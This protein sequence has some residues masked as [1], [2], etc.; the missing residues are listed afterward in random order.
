MTYAHHLRACRTADG[1]D[2]ACLRAV[3]IAFERGDFDEPQGRL[4]LTGV[5][6]ETLDERLGP[7][8]PASKLWPPVRDARPMGRLNQG[9][10]FRP[11]PRHG[12]NA[13]TVHLKVLKTELCA[14]CYRPHPGATSNKQQQETS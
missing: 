13:P 7:K 1:W 11:C 12:K 8:W 2:V 3:N 9:R 4:P 5:H 10:L 6:I 14:Q